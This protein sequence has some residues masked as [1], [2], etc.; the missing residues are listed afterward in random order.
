[1]NNITSSPNAQYLAQY[2]VS[3]PVEKPLPPPI[4]PVSNIKSAGFNFLFHSLRIAALL[5]IAS[6]LTAAVV[7]ISGAPI[8]GSISS[9]IG[10]TAEFTPLTFVLLFICIRYVRYKREENQRFLQ[11]QLVNASF[12]ALQTIPIPKGLM[13]GIDKLRGIIDQQNH[14]LEDLQE[15]FRLFRELYDLNRVLEN[16][17]IQRLLN[18]ISI[19][20]VEKVE[21]IESYR[22][23][24]QKL[25]KG[26]PGDLKGLTQIIEN[27]FKNPS[28]C[29]FRKNTLW[30]KISWFLFYPDKVA[31]SARSENQG[32]HFCDSIEEGN[33]LSRGWTFA[34]PDGKLVTAQFGPG[35]FDP[36]LETYYHSQ[37]QRIHH[38]GFQGH[39]T[40]EDARVEHMSSYNG[41]QNMTVSN[42]PMDG[43]LWKH[44]QKTTDNVSFFLNDYQQKLKSDT[45]YKV[46]PTILDRAF[47]YAKKAF[48]DAKGPLNERMIQ[49]TVQTFICLGELYQLFKTMRSNENA[50]IRTVC[51]QMIDRGA[52][53]TCALR[54]F[55]QLSEGIPFDAQ[56]I[57]GVLLGRATLV[58]NR[59]PQK[60]RFLP[61]IHMLK[62]FSGHDQQLIQAIQEF[63]QTFQLEQT[64]VQNLPKK[65]TFC[66]IQ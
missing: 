39:R 11:D 33:L 54:I 63:K 18:E 21:G 29:V 14:S 23:F 15:V 8:I 34:G 41:C 52:V 2:D 58:E 27:S 32:L 35:T 4:E 65:N 5:I 24:G 20:L 7:Y 13:Y 61:F 17:S 26:Q 25:T 42:T 57:V 38:H 51:K 47:N 3:Q 40:G 37:H 53:S 66:N 55:Y 1:M 6:I 50:M 64:P 30:E 22:K 16:D 62:Y 31:H 9:M 36:I 60:S 12:K 43:P 45:S 49:F 28:F 59:M 19:A 48:K 44:K 56:E 10:I 46:D